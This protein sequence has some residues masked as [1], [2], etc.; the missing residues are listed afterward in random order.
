MKTE[1]RITYEDIS[2]E[3]NISKDRYE[4]II[5]Y[6]IQMIRD[7][8]GKA[9]DIVKEIPLNLKRKERYLAMFIIGHS[10]TPEFSEMD[11]ENQEK[12]LKNIMDASRINREKAESITNDI[13][14]NILNDTEEDIHVI[15]IMK[16]VADSDISEP[17]KDYLTFILGLIYI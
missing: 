9:Q 3:L 14:K 17:E 1:Q 2:K 4:Y 6:I 8:Q 10:S 7:Y 16:K 12:F 11:S 15:D 5:S 13:S